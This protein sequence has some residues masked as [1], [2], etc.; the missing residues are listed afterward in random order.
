MNSDNRKRHERSA[1]AVA[2]L[3][4]QLSGLVNS[5]SLAGGLKS[6]QWSALRF[7]ASAN[8]SARTIA[9]FARLNRTTL[10]SA[11]QTID[12]LVRKGL[13]TK[14]VGEGSDKRV[15]T[16][17]LTEQGRMQLASDPL[18]E[19]TQSLVILSDSDLRKMAAVIRH[20]LSD[21]T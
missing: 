6:S 1:R 11:S 4:V 14:K 15:R 16:L 13:I 18:Y 2:G 21:N 10:S 9:G 12:T 3:I 20:L 7:V 5:I 8:K 17:E 19:I